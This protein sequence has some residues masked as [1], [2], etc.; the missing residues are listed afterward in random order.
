MGGGCISQIIYI[1]FHLKIKV[2][3]EKYL[4]YFKKILPELSMCSTHF[5]FW[6]TTTPLPFNL[7][8]ACIRIIF[9]TDWV[10]KVLCNLCMTSY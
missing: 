3:C 10:C 2:L 6:A 8:L 9:K 4:A 1:F 7:N 5:A